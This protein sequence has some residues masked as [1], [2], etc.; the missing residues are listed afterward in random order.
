MRK[1]NVGNRVI[2]MPSF[3]DA[4]NLQMYVTEHLKEVINTIEYGK[5]INKTV[6]V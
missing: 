4:Q 1:I 2:N 5:T 3:L 6:R